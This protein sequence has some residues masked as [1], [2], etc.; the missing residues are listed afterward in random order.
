MFTPPLSSRP[1]EASGGI[2][3][4]TVSRSEHGKK[5]LFADALARKT[6]STA[7]LWLCLRRS[8]QGDKREP[9]RAVALLH[10]S[11]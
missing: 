7:R 6:R 1:S 9:A 10:L 2:L 11:S 3:Y 8:A 5:R 4:R